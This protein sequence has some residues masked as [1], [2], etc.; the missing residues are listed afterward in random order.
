MATSNTEQGTVRTAAEIDAELAGIVDP[1]EGDEGGGASGNGPDVAIVAEATRKGWVPKD[2]YKGDP[3]K[4]VDATK[5][6]E[7]GN[8]FT[9]NLQR[10]LANVKQQLADFQGTKQKFV[11]FMEERLAAKDAELKDAI[12]ALRVQKSAATREGDD[13]LAVQ[14]E[15]RIEVLKGQRE[16]VKKIPD[17]QKPPGDQVNMTDP[18]LVEWIEDDNEWF[19]DD[20]KLREYSV[21]LANELVQ[22]GEN[23][24]DGKR[25]TGRKFLNLVRER[26]EEEFPR[27][28]KKTTSASTGRS[29]LVAGASG[30]R[31]S[32]TA[33]KTE[34]DLPR[35]D[36]EIMRDLIKGG[37]TTK[38]KF[39]NSYFSR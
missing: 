1:P 37:F 32:G 28:F 21:N 11:Q 29:D 16:E 15:D 34:A 18:V 19:R 6:V 25:L 4:W 3:D 26:M 22:K 23:M 39:L 5:F 35:E 8:N 9:K 33:G 38:E 14:L 31:S 2:Q 13:E 36:R 17:Q 10:E 7:R 30:G 24:V 12:S 20:P 27:R